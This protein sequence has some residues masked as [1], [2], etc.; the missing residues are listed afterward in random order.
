M[1]DE[2]FRQHARLME[3]AIR[4]HIDR[5]W[6]DLQDALR[7]DAPATRLLALDQEYADSISA[8]EAVFGRAPVSNWPEVQE[9]RRAWRAEMEHRAMHEAGHRHMHGEVT[10]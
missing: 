7:L 10:P 9:R 3:R 8:Y 4:T 2:S 1:Q 6:K 5:S